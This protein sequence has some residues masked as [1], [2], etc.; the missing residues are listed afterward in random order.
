MLDVRACCVCVRVCACARTRSNRLEKLVSAVRARRARIGE[1][2]ISFKRDESVS[3]RDFRHSVSAS[4]LLPSDRLLLLLP[5][6]ASVDDSSSKCD[7]SVFNSL[8]GILFDYRSPLVVTDIVD[9]SCGCF[10][11][12]FRFN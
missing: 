2:V 12:S 6:V 11:L 7:S 10:L 1:S 3:L 4:A 5:S 8:K 9:G